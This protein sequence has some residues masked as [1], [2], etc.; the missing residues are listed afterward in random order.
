MK[1]N[2]RKEDVTKMMIKEAIKEWLDEKFAE[3][4]RWTFWGLVAFFLAGATYAIFWL[5]GWRHQ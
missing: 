3:L 4:G 1:H 5:N 2:R